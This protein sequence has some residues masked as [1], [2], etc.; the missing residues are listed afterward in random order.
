MR[1]FHLAFPVRDLD[2]TRAFYG[3]RARAAVMGR[4]APTWQDFD[5][6]GHQLSAHLAA[7]GDG[8]SGEVDG[9]AVPIPHFGVV[10]GIDEW[11]ALAE[12][13]RG[14][15][16]GLLD[17]AADPLRRR[18]GGAG[19]VLPARSGRQHAGV[20]G[21][22][23]HGGGLRDRGRRVTRRDAEPAAAARDPQLAARHAGDGPDPRPLRRRGAGRAAMRRAS[24]PS[25]R[26][27]R[28]TIT[29]S[30]HG[31]RVGQC[32]GAVPRRS[33]GGSRAHHRI[34]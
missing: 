3:E 25:R 26:C 22:P 2:A 32:A 28:R 4:S 19:H 12:R 34:G 13:L 8:G 20:Q 33:S 29:I 15:G 16:A 31:S 14:A 9:K 5:F 7:A 10:L 30:M 1:P 24:T 17:R 21:L 6:F 23:R 27:C 18:A 11:S